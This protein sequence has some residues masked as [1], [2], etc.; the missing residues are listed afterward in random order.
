MPG[1]NLRRSCSTFSVALLLI[2]IL[3]GAAPLG[4]QDPLQGRWE[5]TV[6]SQRGARPAVATFTRAGDAYTGT[7]SGVRPDGDLPF[8]QVTLAGDS[9]SAIAEISSPQGTLPIKFAF[10]LQGDTLKG[11][12]DLDIGGQAFSFTID[13]KRVSGATSA[14]ATAPVPPDT[15]TPAAGQPAPPRV[16]RK[17]VP[18]P[19]QQQSLDYFVGQWNFK[20]L[21]R[22]SPVGPGS[23]SGTV[24]FTK[25]ADGTF[26]DARTEGQSDEGKYQETAVV[27]FDDEKKMLA[28]F[29][30]RTRGVE[31]L[32]LGDWGS[33]MTIRFAISPVRIKGQTVRL[34]RTISV[35]SA[36]SFSVSEEFSVDGGPFERLG[37]GTF[38]KVVSEKKMP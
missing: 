29:E 38:T 37:N 6:Q 15:G 21:A 26:L 17:S 28:F 16:T 4:R 7:I 14:T 8:K 31:L 11:K 20:W 36:D 33:A 10:V 23:R 9:V 3:G 34:K 18:Q 30:R 22:E 1:R 32:S 19:L 27:G 13:L 35:V 5:G 12:G 2:L 24:T 25:T